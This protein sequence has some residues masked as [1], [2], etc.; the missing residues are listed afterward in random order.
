MM[1]KTP[2]KLSKVD[3]VN[4]EYDDN[5]VIKEVEEVEEKNATKRKKGTK[6]RKIQILFGS[7]KDGDDK[8]EVSDDVVY[9]SDKNAILYIEAFVGLF[10]KKRMDESIEFDV[11]KSDDED[12]AETRSELGQDLIAEKVR[13]GGSG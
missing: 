6:K 12:K 9:D 8:S 5:D 3:K 7:E 11:H 13:D 1:R 10:S 2:K 4:L